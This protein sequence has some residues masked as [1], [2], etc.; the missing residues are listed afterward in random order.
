MSE[1]QPVSEVVYLRK[2]EAYFTNETIQ[3][4]V[5]LGVVL[6][7]IHDRLVAEGYTIKNGKIYKENVIQ[8]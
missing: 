2:E 8:A 6:R 5:E 1:K 4:L 3:S 7:S